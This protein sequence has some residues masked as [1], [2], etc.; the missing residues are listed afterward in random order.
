MRYVGLT[1][2]S[3]FMGMVAV[4]LLIVAV[5]LAAIAALSVW[6]KIGPA[7]RDLFRG[8]PRPPSHPL[9]SDDSK[10]LNRRRSHSSSEEAQ[11]DVEL[12]SK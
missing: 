5:L 12:S 3:L 2:N 4:L 6:E 11:P 7:L 8:G 9:P 1:H 10:I